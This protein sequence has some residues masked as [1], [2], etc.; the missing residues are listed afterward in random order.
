MGNSPGGSG[1]AGVQGFIVLG[2]NQNNFQVNTIYVGRQ[3][4]QAGAAPAA[5]ADL[6]SFAGTGGTWNLSGIGGGKTALN[7]AFNDIAGTGTI[8]VGKVDLTGGTFNGTLSALNIGTGTVSGATGGGVGTF[9]MAAGTTTA[10][11]VVIASTAGTSDVL[12]G[13]VH[14]CRAAA[15]LWPATARASSGGPDRC[16]QW[17]GHCE[18]VRHWRAGDEQHRVEPPRSQLRLQLQRRH[19]EQRRQL[20]RGRFDELDRF[21]R[22]TPAHPRWDFDPW[23]PGLHRLGHYPAT[24]RAGGHHLPARASLRPMPN[25]KCTSRGE[26]ST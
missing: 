17:C 10:D 21:G 4:S 25:R 2:N 15:S 22:H 26:R 12:L 13:H 18:P 3:K 1:S 14:A 20:L 19:A 9:I 11:T 6:I 8:S 16:H 5:A 7:I 24:A 23:H